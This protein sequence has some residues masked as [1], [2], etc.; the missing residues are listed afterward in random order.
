[1]NI[2]MKIAG[3]MLVVAMCSCSRTPEATDAPATR[4]KIERVE[5]SVQTG[6]KS[7]SGTVVESSG[8]MLSFSAAG[9]IRQM[10][11]GVGDRVTKGQIIATLDP[12]TLRHAYEIALATL[13]QAQD[14]YDRMKQLHEAN[15]L[16]DI[17]WVEIQN[18]LSQAQNAAAIARKGLDDASLYAPVSGYVSEKLADA[19]MN[20]APGMPVVK[21]V[22]INPVKV[23]IAVPENEIA[24]V[25]TG[26]TAHISVGAIGGKQFSGT[27][28]EKGV[29]ANPLSRTY[30]VRYEVR[31]P[32]GD[33]L[34]GMIC[35]VTASA[36]STRSIIA[37]PSDAV[38]LDADN[39]NFVWLA[40]GGKAEKRI[41]FVDGMTTGTRIIIHSGLSAGDS[42]IV[43][44]QQKV[45][46][47]THVLN[48][49]K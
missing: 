34:P 33:L 38:L 8:T 36:D 24:N 5:T 47:G 32:E 35:D 1:M 26:S 21:V 25:S 39:Q 17:K 42:I 10:H 15:A 22:D 16:P 41:V 3:V 30:D 27:V 14:A 45:S 6:G 18:T 48:I 9:T 13:N 31:N 28:A 46:Q 40:S 7:Y 49:S 44:G 12:S 19:G 20:V 37:V 11:V 23:S 29:S 4:V 2:P 43:S